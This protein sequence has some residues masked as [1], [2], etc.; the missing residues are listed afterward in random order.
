MIAHPRTGT[1]SRQ[2]HYPR[3][4]TRSRQRQHPR[5]KPITLGTSDSSGQRQYQFLSASPKAVM[6]F[7]TYSLPT[8]FFGTA[9]SGQ[10]GQKAAIRAYFADQPGLGCFRLVALG[11]WQVG[12]LL[13]VFFLMFGK[14]HRLINNRPP[15][16]PPPPPLWGGGASP[17]LSF[18]GKGGEGGV[19]CLSLCCCV[20]RV[21]GSAET[22]KKL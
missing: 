17:S 18:W 21:I 9:A 8:V 15:P 14:L 10:T 2:R 16:P 3:T 13:T 11:Y 20:C 6:D 19:F 7:Y 4:G 22:Y 12:T 1:R 5:T